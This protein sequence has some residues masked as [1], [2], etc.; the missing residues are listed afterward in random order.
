MLSLVGQT[1]WSQQFPNAGSQLQQITPVPALP[2]PSP[3]IRIE[4]P[5]VDTG[6]APAGQEK[7]VVNSL[8]FDG[9]TAF[10]EAQLRDVAGF[11]P[12]NALTLAE[13]RSIAAKVAD[14]YRQQGYF[15]AQAYLPAQE[16][17]DGRVTVAVVEG[18]Y[19]AISLRNQSR[20]S[21]QVATAMLGDV[22]SGE[23]VRIADLERG[24]L[25][26][27]DLPGVAV[28]STLAP[29][30]NA[31]ASDLIVDVDPGQTVTG[32]ID[33]D[34]HGNRYTGRPR[35]GAVVNLNNLAGLGDV[36]SVRMLTSLDGLNYGRAS[37]QIQA[38]QAKIGI[39]YA[40]LDYKLGREFSSLDANGTAKVASIYGSYPLVRSRD[41][42][43]YVQVAFENKRFTDRID[44]TSTS[45]KKET[46]VLTLSLNGDRLNAFG[47]RSVSSYAF[48][49]V[50][51]TLDQK[52]AAVR[53]V[54]R[55]SA[56]TEGSYEKLGVN[57]AH[58]QGVA[59]DTFLYAGISGQLASK[60][61][62]ASEKMSLGGMGAVRAYPEGEAQGD[63]GY[64]FTLEARQSLPQL[65]SYVPGQVQLVA[66]VD[67]GYV[68]FR[69]DNWAQG[70]NSRTLS[71][72][73]VGV[74]WAVG[75]DYL[76]NAFYAHT[77]GSAQ[78]ESAPPSSSRVWLQAV[79]YF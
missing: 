40:H 28:K 10:S 33:A 66:F 43:T 30:A 8:A 44:A 21:N 46:Q 49:G 7:I 36:A 76:F 54:D 12:G 51:G 67:T 24:L 38:G 77:L 11:V 64:V 18:R 62:D 57:L 56:R 9:A 78:A 71:G 48:N 32:S 42:N 55:M 47:G 29:G 15:V 14:Y 75:R 19:G 23:T 58:L 52:N 59:R 79:K 72:A 74:N 45:A 37:Y 34:N 50:L 25:L 13:L 73:G 70:R 22:T 68:K 31:G 3:D 60:N 26:M 53:A 69:K 41:A 17:N 4:R 65:A 27:S 63:Q 2:K 61:L 5:D 16:V 39:A 20:L 6:A 1:A 35:G